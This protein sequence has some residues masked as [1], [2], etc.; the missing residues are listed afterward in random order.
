MM[1]LPPRTPPPESKAYLILGVAGILLGV[2][3]IYSV[4]HSSEFEQGGPNEYHRSTIWGG[5][6]WLMCGFGFLIP[7]IMRRIRK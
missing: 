3:T 1:R 7:A 4:T 2:L 6:G 5:I